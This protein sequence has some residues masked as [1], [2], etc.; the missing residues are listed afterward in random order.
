MDAAG[1]V[2]VM[3]TSFASLFAGLAANMPA[4]VDALAV[5]PGVP[6]MDAG[7]SIVTPATPASYACRVQFDVPTQGMR[8]AD[9]F[10]ERDAR[11]LVLAFARELDPAARLTV[12]S[13][14]HA[15]TWSLLSVTRDPVGVG[16]EC[17]A[18]RTQ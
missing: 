14:P 16:F 15:G 8:L 6:V 17:R 3:A 9:G 2:R 10:D 7:G 1:S 5:W 12:A 4:F 18:R 13:G 11:V